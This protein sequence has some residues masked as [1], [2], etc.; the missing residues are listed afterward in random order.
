V[1]VI[2]RLVEHDSRRAAWLLAAALCDILR[3]LRIM[4]ASLLLRYHILRFAHHATIIFCASL[5]IV[6]CITVAASSLRPYL[7]DERR[8][9]R[10][11]ER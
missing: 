11:R 8:R 2:A 1:C 9:E 3:S 7:F 5:R 10:E 6:V 4:S